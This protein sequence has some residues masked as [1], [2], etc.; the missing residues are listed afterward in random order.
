MEENAGEEAKTEG[1]RETARGT[2]N[3]TTAGT[4]ENL[5]R[6]ETQGQKNK[7]KGAK[8]KEKGTGDRQAM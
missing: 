8:D 4:T 1:Y 7:P 3:I 5:A 6:Q 2:K